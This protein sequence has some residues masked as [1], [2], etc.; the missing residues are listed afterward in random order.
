M[1]N[2]FDIVTAACAVCVAGYVAIVVGYVARFDL[3]F[4]LP[5]IRSAAV[6]VAVVL[7]ALIAIDFFGKK[8][9]KAK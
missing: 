2:K 6:V 3:G 4:S 1:E 8:F 7:A 5:E 9:G